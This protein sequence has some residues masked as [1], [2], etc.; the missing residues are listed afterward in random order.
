MLGPNGTTLPGWPI[1]SIGTASGPV[2][3]ADRSVFYVSGTGMVWGHDRGGDIIEPVQQPPAGVEG[4]VEEA[5]RVAEDPHV[6]GGL[7]G[8]GAAQRGRPGAAPHWRRARRQQNWPPC[9]APIPR[10]RPGRQPSPRRQGRVSGDREPL[11]PPGPAIAAWGNSCG[12]QSGEPV[13][14][15]NPHKPSAATT[16]PPGSSTG[17]GSS[18]ECAEYGLPWQPK[19][20]TLWRRPRR[21]RPNAVD[22][23]C[24]SRPY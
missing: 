1:T 16:R 14:S 12:A 4:H 7:A 18:E 13:L 23:G 9:G 11:V 21:A 19:R 24:D 2:I 17:G 3:T 20:T 6:V 22:S 8:A 15:R 5:R 10:R